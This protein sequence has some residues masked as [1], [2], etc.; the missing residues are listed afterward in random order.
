MKTFELPPLPYALNALEPFISE[1]TLSFHYGKHHK[2]YVDNLNKLK[3]GTEFEDASLEVIMLNAGGG[4]FNNAAQVWNHTFYW[5]CMKPAAEVNNEPATELLEAIVKKWG[6]FEK[7]KEA[8]SVA[9]AGNF[10]SGWTWLVTNEKD[11]LEIVS[12]SNAD[13]PLRND[14]EPLLVIDVWEHAYY[15]DRQNARPNYIADFWNIVDWEA[16]SARY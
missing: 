12:T 6:S 1:K 5:N 9:A 8:F 3:E 10:G 14:K 11:E 2:A 16:V 13:N 4:L 15:L 7:F